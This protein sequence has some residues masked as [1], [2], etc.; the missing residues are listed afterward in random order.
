[1]KLDQT[2]FVFSDGVKCRVLT[3]DEARKR[4]EF[5]PDDWRHTATIVLPIVLERILNGEAKIEDYK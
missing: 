2:G 3:I 1:M 5:I 4:S